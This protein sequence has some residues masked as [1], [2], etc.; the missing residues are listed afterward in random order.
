MKKT[1][2]T[3]GLLSAAV[4]VIMMTLTTVFAKQIGFDN[5]AIIG[6]ST[7][8]LSLS[9]VFF[10]I[11]SYRD[12]V[13]NGSITFGKAFLI[14]LM[15][16][17]ISCICYVVAWLVIY[18]NFMPDFLQQYG[19]HVADKMRASG[20]TQEAINQK[21]NEMK[22]FE[23]MYRNPLINAAFTFMEPFP[24]GV[25]ITLLSA[26]ILKRKSVAAI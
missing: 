6:Y 9:F 23:K 14:G 3:F 8:I 25:V 2:L 7:I 1:I 19:E 15:I 12:R 11:K 4:I 16:T 10:G 21:M 18:Y 20:A 17:L 13:G 24:I 22:E 5:G 26:L